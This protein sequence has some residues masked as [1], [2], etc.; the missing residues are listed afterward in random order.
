MSSAT[1]VFLFI[2]LWLAIFWVWKGNRK[3]AANSILSRVNCRVEV[4][5]EEASLGQPLQQLRI[6]RLGATAACG[7]EKENSKS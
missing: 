6:L 3:L 4:P 7:L 2:P 1:H 5:G